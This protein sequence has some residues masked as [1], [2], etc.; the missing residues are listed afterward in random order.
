MPPRDLWSRV[1][2]Y[3]HRIGTLYC[4]ICGQYRESIDGYGSCLC[5]ENSDEQR[6]WIEEHDH[7]GLTKC[8]VG[9]VFIHHEGL[10]HRLGS[11]YGVCREDL[12]EGRRE[13]W[14]SVLVPVRRF[15]GDVS[16]GGR[17]PGT[18]R[19]GVKRDIVWLP[20][21]GSRDICRNCGKVVFLDRNGSWRHFSG[22]PDMS[23]NSAWCSSRSKCPDNWVAAVAADGAVKVTH[24]VLG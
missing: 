18:G 3:T 23:I 5:V 1:N 12:L 6:A 20:V 14:L 4:L 7:P 15:E 22:G 13:G 24:E 8:P 17:F 21:P 11:V 19:S 9:T 2:R 10:F 16:G